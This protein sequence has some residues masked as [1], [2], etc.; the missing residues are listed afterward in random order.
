MIHRAAI[1]LAAGQ[2]TRMKSPLS[3]VLHKVA[4]RTMLDR[5]IDAAQGA[6]CERIV[7]VAGPGR[8]PVAEHAARRLGAEAVAIQ[9]PPLGT[10]HAVLAARAALANFS[11]DVVVTNADCPL[12]SAEDLEPLFALRASGS[13]LA[14]LGFRP[15]DPA[16]YGR[17][18]TTRAGAVEAIVEARD[19]SPAQRAVADC[20]A[21][22]LA[23]PAQALFG[24]LDKVGNG[25]AKGEYYLTDVVAVARAAGAGVGATYAVEEAVMGAD[26]QAGLAVA[27]AAFQRRARA[28]LMREGVN[29]VAPDTVH[30]A[31]DT[32]IAGGAVVEPFVVFAPG[33]VVETG[34]VIRAF[35]H[36][37]GCV[38]RAGALVGP[39][40]RLRPGADIGED[41]HIGNFVE[42]KKVKVGKGAKANHLAYLGDGSVGAG[43]NIG[44]GTI[45][46]NYDGFDK[47]D[48][49]IGEGAFVGS[50]SSL[51]APVT[52]GAGA[53]TGSGSVITKDVAADAL[54]LGRGFQTEKAGWASAF[55]ARKQTQRKR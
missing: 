39:Y 23:S 26:D 33:V 35:S 30:L 42:V 9:D 27:E 4:G 54:A 15:A 16:L 14:I 44:A 40:A 12:L 3:K 8:S 11:G 31:F 50:N 28:A 7:V 36:L 45:F 47:F 10:G 53:Y 52:I 43:A 55:R 17:I 48:T 32:R 25:N 34:A 29:L 2:G 1:I 13:D 49:H 5:A 51:V 22:M 19:A 37:E 46:C 18:I 21:G 6:G 24:W 20:Y 38:V 41:A